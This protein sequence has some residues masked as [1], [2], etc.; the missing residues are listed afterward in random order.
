MTASP[1]NMPRA[2]LVDGIEIDAVAA[3]VRGCA[4]VSALDSGPFGEVASYLPGRI[5]PGVAVDGS[6]IR[7][8]VRSRWGVPATDVAT[9]ITAAVAPL[10]GPRPID[11][12]IAD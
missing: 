2:A 11:V 12:T 6:R 3:I 4:G 7:V 9:Q 5:V 1:L 8:Q 10:A